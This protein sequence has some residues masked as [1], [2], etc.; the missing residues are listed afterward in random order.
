MALDF[1]AIELDDSI[2]M[3][4]ARLSEHIDFDKFDEKGANGYTFFGTNSFLNRRIVVKF[5]YWGGDRENFAEPAHLSQL[6]NSAILEVYD[7]APV[8]S[9]WAYTNGYSAR[10]T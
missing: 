8:D 4:L 7:A 10:P 9:D 2:R 1:A 5:Y 3:V 6:K